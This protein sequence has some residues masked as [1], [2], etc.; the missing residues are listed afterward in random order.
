M[1]AGAKCQVRTT[2]STYPLEFRSSALPNP[3]HRRAIKGAGEISLAH[4]SAPFLDE[5]A[6]FWVVTHLTES[7]PN[8]AVFGRKWDQ[9]DKR[10]GL[11]RGPPY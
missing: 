4:Q 7:L 6:Q 5:S 9:G 3:A 11:D 8:F 2:R 10:G 1:T